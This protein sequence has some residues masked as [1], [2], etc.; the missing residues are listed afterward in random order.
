MK[1]ADS[2][3]EVNTADPTVIRLRRIEG[4]VRGLQRMLEEGRD[5]ASVLT[6]LMAARAALDAVGR[7]IIQEH[8]D[9]CLDLPNPE[10]AREQIVRMV[11][12]FLKLA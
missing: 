10:E 3:Q 8:I 5:C 7:A 12:L 1:D 4:Q 6:Q 9:R 2:V 11:E